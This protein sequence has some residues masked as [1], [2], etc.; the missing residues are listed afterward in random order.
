MRCFVSVF[1]WEAFKVGEDHFL[2]SA[3]Y[4]IIPDTQN[5][6]TTYTTSA[7]SSITTSSAIYRWQGAE[8]FVAAH[9]LNTPPVSDW[10]TFTTD[11]GDVYLVCANGQAG[12]SQ[13]FKVKMV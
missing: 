2:L 10:E 8:K 6:L 11:S 7:T 13:L 12:V 3:E 1:D 9:R 4:S 5:T